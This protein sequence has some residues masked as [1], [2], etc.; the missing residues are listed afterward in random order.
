[1]QVTNL[2]YRTA[3]AVTPADGA[4]LPRGICRALYTGAGGA[5]ALQT[6]EGL[7]LTIA[8]LPAGTVFPLMVKRVLSTGT[9][10]TGIHALY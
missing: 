4:D 7:A 1:M 9:T 6:E 10:A 5:I 2:E 8:S 3:V